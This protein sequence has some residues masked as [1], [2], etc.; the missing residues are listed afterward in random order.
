M[1]GGVSHVSHTLSFTLQTHHWGY[2]TGSMWLICITRLISYTW[3]SAARHYFL[4]QIVLQN[5]HFCKLSYLYL[6]IFCKQLYRLF[7]FANC[8]SGPVFLLKK[9]FLK[10]GRWVNQFVLFPLQTPF[11][12]T[13]LLRFWLHFCT[14]NFVHES[15]LGNIKPF[16]IVQCALFVNSQVVAVP[17]HPPCLDRPTLK[18]TRAVAKGG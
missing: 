12:I 7:F 4:L 17:F 6:I 5:N 10:N 14:A 3:I 8:R 13:W 16:N 2:N 1:I 9:L 15:K 11:H 18:R